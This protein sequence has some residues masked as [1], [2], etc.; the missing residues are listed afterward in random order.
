MNQGYIHLH[1]KIK[2]NFLWKE[3]RT[4]SRAEAWID[5]LMEV[6]WQDFPEEVTIGCKKIL[7]CQGESLNSLE[8]WAMR[9]HWSKSK[10]K[11]FLGLLADRH[12]IRTQNETQTTR[13]SVCNY[14]EYQRPRNANGTR[15]ETE[16]TPR[17][18]SKEVKKKEEK[19]CAAAPSR[20]GN[21][22]LV[23]VG[24]PYKEKIVCVFNRHHNIPAPG[25]SQ[26]LRR[27]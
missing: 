5:I 17:I 10:V 12:A 9:W 7:C 26:P 22:T 1:R 20:H 16:L 13:I 2:D 4:F 15:T 14:L 24:I 11:R 3:R 8:T 19:L 6:R 25:I 21:E 23:K 27:L 18:I